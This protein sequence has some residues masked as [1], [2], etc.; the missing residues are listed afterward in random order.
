MNDTILQTVQPHKQ[1]E[2]FL[3][4]GKY[5]VWNTRTYF[6]I[7]DCFKIWG[8]QKTSKRLTALFTNVPIIFAILIWSFAYKTMLS[9]ADDL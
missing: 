3:N 9:L 8:I 4:N 6:D 2:Q 5:L 7:W 1:I